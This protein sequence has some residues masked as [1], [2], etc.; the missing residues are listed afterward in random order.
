MEDD[1]TEFF[2]VL[3]EYFA[4]EFA[5]LD[6]ADD[7][8]T[9]AYNKR[10]RRFAP[11]LH[12]NVDR[13][14]QVGVLLVRE[15]FRLF[16][17]SDEQEQR[18]RFRRSWV[19]RMGMQNMV[20]PYDDRLFED[21]LVAT[22]KFC[23]G[24]SRGLN[25]RLVRMMNEF[26]GSVAS[27][28]Q[29][30]NLLAFG[31]SIFADWG[32]D[33][34]HDDHERTYNTEEESCASRRAVYEAVVDHQRR[35]RFLLPSEIGCAVLSLLI[36]AGR[37]KV[38]RWSEA[39]NL[40]AGLADDRADIEPDSP[41]ARTL[42]VITS[43]PLR[44][45]LFRHA[46]HSHLLVFYYDLERL[47]H[48][49]RGTLS[50]RDSIPT[51]EEICNIVFECREPLFDKNAWFLEMDRCRDAV[52]N[53]PE[54]AFSDVAETL[55]AWHS[56]HDLSRGFNNIHAM[57][58]E[59]HDG[60]MAMPDPLLFFVRE[61]VLAP[62]VV[63][64]EGWQ[65]CRFGVE[66]CRLADKLACEH[67]SR[68]MQFII[69]LAQLRQPCDLGTQS[70]RTWFALYAALTYRREKCYGFIYVDGELAEQTEFERN[71]LSQFWPSL[72]IKIAGSAEKRAYYEQLQHGADWQAVF[73][74]TRYRLQPFIVELM[75]ACSPTFVEQCEV[76]FGARVRAFFSNPVE[77][78]NTFLC[79]VFMLRDC[80]YIARPLFERWRIH[81][82]VR[83]LR[84]ATHHSLAADLWMLALGHGHVWLAADLFRSGFPAYLD[85][86]NPDDFE[87]RYKPLTLPMLVERRLAATKPNQRPEARLQMRPGEHGMARAWLEREMRDRQGMVDSAPFWPGPAFIADAKP[88]FRRARI[89]SLREVYTNS[90]CLSH[91][92]RSVSQWRCS[93][94][95]LGM[96]CADYARN[97]MR[98]MVQESEMLCAVATSWISLATH[99]IASTPGLVRSLRSLCVDAVHCAGILDLG[100]ENA[101]DGSGAMM[102]HGGGTFHIPSIVLL[103]DP[104]EDLP[105]CDEAA[106]RRIDAIANRL[107]RQAAVCIHD[108][109]REKFSSVLVRFAEYEDWNEILRSSTDK[110]HPPL[111]D[112][113]LL[114]IALAIGPDQGEGFCTDTPARTFDAPY[115]DICLSLHAACLLSH[116]P[117][118]PCVLRGGGGS[119]RL[120]VPTRYG[121]ESVSLEI[122]RL[123]DN[124]GV[125]F[126]FLEDVSFGFTVKNDSS[127]VQ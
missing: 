15:L 93:P 115:S 6:F 54:L 60:D 11:D 72:L 3:K 17:G 27:L 92:A 57:P 85:M 126:N 122:A 5:G 49:S 51:A 38:A 1:T 55:V 58:D 39:D 101:L 100:N 69:W 73:S 79:S 110:M 59:L 123:G 18:A 25:E 45:F 53:N 96:Q 52:F 26:V 13:M 64:A 125:G 14:A 10:F 74:H 36:C 99:Y 119:E 121:G 97:F 83:L 37:N 50:L 80:M 20:D 86:E 120:V 76:A 106:F 127:V 94:F 84:G 67:E 24:F 44:E 88:R 111:T 23:A 32:F 2:D 82:Y 33:R 112:D 40:L 117:N 107:E 81:I 103:C 95:A 16:D 61:L 78:F 30:I 4:R 104:L 46:P 71:D 56:T 41:E 47:R 90:S 34:C 118:E 62:A 35:L 42:E 108:K 98:L 12:S 91:G 7:T 31:F 21:L 66:N 29:A 87:E 102:R 75:G 114:A 68:L 48:P 9:F 19:A 63:A 89:L 124:A 109:S 28:C 22:N 116:K 77:M 70:I 105:G 113:N 65:R 43:L 8:Q